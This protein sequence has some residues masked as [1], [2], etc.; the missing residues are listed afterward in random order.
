MQRGVP[1]DSTRPWGWRPLEKM[2]VTCATSPR[3]ISI[4][5]VLT[6]LDCFVS[7]LEKLEENCSRSRASSRKAAR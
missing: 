1:S 5:E 3:R 6:A 7:A 2:L 4:N